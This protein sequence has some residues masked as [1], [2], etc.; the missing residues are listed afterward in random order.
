MIDRQQIEETPKLPE[1][2]NPEEN[3][4]PSTPVLPSK[5]KTSHNRRKDYVKV[6][7][8]DMK[9]TCQ[10]ELES[11]LTGKEYH[12]EHVNQWCR[13]LSESIQSR[14]VQITEDNYKIVAQVFIGAL[15]DDGIHAAVQCTT[16]NNNDNFFTVT[17]KGKDMFVVA[18]VMTFELSPE[19]VDSSL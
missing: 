3:D 4:A 6:R 8:Q 1:L 11:F 10:R 16:G 14:I 19:T 18:S 17:Y 9:T 12:A 13:T 15:F 5:I 2:T 7:L